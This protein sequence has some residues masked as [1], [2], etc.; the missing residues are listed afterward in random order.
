M[1]YSYVNRHFIGNYSGKF[2]V[3]SLGAAVLL[4]LN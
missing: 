2:R 1:G 4:V 3:R